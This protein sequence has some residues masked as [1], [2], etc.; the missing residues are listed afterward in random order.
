METRRAL[1]KQNIC[2]QRG[3]VR[4]CQ[5]QDFFLCTRHQARPHQSPLKFSKWPILL[6]EVAAVSKIPERDD[7]V[8]KIRQRSVFS[9]SCGLEAA[10]GF[11]S[12]PFCATISAT[13]LVLVHKAW[14]VLSLSMT[15]PK[16][17]WPHHNTPSTHHHHRNGCCA[18][19]SRPVLD[20]L[21]RL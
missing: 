19:S 15:P 11:I 2:Y 17:Q 16:R 3:P 9:S 7:Q 1:R 5:M 6:C 20:A 13:T 12:V 4:S 21:H 18:S 8:P 10:G 14:R